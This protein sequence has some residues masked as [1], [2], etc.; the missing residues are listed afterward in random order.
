MGTDSFT[1]RKPAGVVAAVAVSLCTVFA[2]TPV[3]VADP[4]DGDDG[5]GS[6][7]DGG[8]DSGGAVEEPSGGGGEEPAGGGVEEPSAPQEEP[9]GTHEEPGGTHDEPGGTH[10]EPGATHDEPGGGNETPGG[11]HEEPGGSEAP[12]GT[13]EEPGSGTNEVPGE[14]PG[15]DTAGAGDVAEPTPQG[16]QAEATDVKTASDSEVTT[17]TTTEMTSE[18]YSSFQSSM[19]SVVSTSTLTTGFTL[20][21]PVALWNSGWISYDRYYR[22]VFTNPYRTPL[23]I[24]Y[25]SGGQ[26]QVFTVPPLARA[27]VN[28]PNAGVY[29]FTAVTRPQSGPPTNLSVGSFSG[30]GYEP[31][32]GQAPPQRPASLNTQKN[33][34]VQVKFDRGASAPFRVKSLTDLGTDPTVNGATKVLLD[35]EI[36]AWGQWSKTDKGDAL[37]VINQTQ[38]LPG[39][40][41]PGQ[42]PLPGYNVK[43]TAAT[44][45]EKRSWIDKNKTL[46]I[47]V[48]VGAGVLALAAVGLILATRRRRSG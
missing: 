15:T 9:G 18:E 41:P 4:F 6:S 8:G 26:P 12:G 38:T 3:A 35:E 30:G 27:A 1:Y 46:L 7:Y 32:P 11:T 19:S 20:S 2:G 29:S 47:G 21:S 31:A 10:D 44:A 17:T 13:H 24:V 36:P 22:P 39:V 16:P 45:A 28:V 25:T 23:S 43:L 34:L 14:E 48:A 33:V 42:E 40:N 37:F 5:G